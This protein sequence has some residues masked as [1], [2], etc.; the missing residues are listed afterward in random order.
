[1]RFAR[2][3]VE[4]IAVA[5]TSPLDAEC[6]AFL[7]AVRDRQR[8]LADGQSGVAVVRALAAG[9]QSLD[10]NGVPVRLESIP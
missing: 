1:V 3:A 8:P 7:R 6:T 4:S 5:D 9:Q 10:T 2:G